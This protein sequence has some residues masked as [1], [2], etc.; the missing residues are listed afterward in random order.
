MLTVD[1]KEQKMGEKFDF[2][3]IV[4]YGYNSKTC[5]PTVSDTAMLPGSGTCSRIVGYWSALAVMAKFVMAN[6]KVFCVLP[7]Y[8]NTN[9]TLN[10]VENEIGRPTT[11]TT[12]CRL[13]SSS[14]L[15]TGL[16]AGSMSNNTWKMRSAWRSAISSWFRRSA[17]AAAELADER[18]GINSGTVL[19]ESRLPMLEGY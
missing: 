5:H 13:T 2:T 9:S 17:N 12:S 7:S 4:H 1:V 6:S 3:Y 18:L 8:W 19:L 15:E 14:Q 10:M 11:T 16:T